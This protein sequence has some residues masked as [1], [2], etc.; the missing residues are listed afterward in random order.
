[1]HVAWADVEAFA[2]W[3]GKEL[4]SEAE[5]EFACRGGLDGATYA[6]GEEFTPPNQWMANTWQ[7]EFPIQNIGADGHRGTA[8]VGSYP[9]NGYRL[10]DMIGNVWE[11]TA[12]WYQA[13]GELAAHDCCTVANPRGGDQE[14]SHDP[15]LQQVATREE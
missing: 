2:H 15:Q 11:W 14:R 10:Y 5:W 8:P 12:D 9:P 1:V 6:W 7:G 13:H 3:A 4:P